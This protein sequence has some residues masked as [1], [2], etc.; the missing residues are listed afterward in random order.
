MILHRLHDLVLGGRDIQL[1]RG[2]MGVPEDPLHVG[3]RQLRVV[4]HP[5]RGAVSQVVQRPISAERGVDPLE[6]AV[7]RVV[8]QRSIRPAQRPP[9]RL[10]ATARN[11]LPEQVP[12][13]EPQ[14]HERVRRRRHLLHGARALAH[15]ADQLFARVHV[16]AA[17]PEQLR[18]ARPS[19]DPERHQRPVP[20]RRQRGE[21]L[22]EPVVG[23]RARN[24]PRH[25][26]AIPADPLRP[27]RLHRVVVRVRPPRASAQIQRERVDD[28]PAAAI[29]A[30]VVEPAQH[31]LAM[32]DARRCVPVTRSGFAGHRVRRAQHPAGPPR[33]PR[34]RRLQ[35]L[36]DG[37]P[38]PTAEVA[39]LHPRRAIPRDSHRVEEPPPS[40]Q[41]HSV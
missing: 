38:D 20:V 30:E 4:G 29:T 23:D 10:P 18:R 21:Q 2:Q 41:V 17:H 8:G 34:P 1:C 33:R 11:A 26:R 27:P 32:R 14:P 37:Q 3:Q 15:H 39:G 13:I 5:G 16:A 36:F 35:P 19:G 9:Q 28:R 24:P 25:R 22:V 12:L 6:H 40:Q 7:R 31:R